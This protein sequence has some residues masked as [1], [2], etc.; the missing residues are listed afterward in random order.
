LN[1][2]MGKLKNDHYP[3]TF[4]IE[5]EKIS[6]LIHK[7]SV[8]FFKKKVFRGL[9]DN[10]LRPWYPFVEVGFDAGGAYQFG[11][12]RIDDDLT[13]KSNLAARTGLYLGTDLTFYIS[14]RIGYGFKYDYRSLLGG[15][16]YYQYLGPMATVRFLERKQDKH[17]FFSISCGAGWMVQKNAP[18]QLVQ[19]RPRIEMNA[20]SLSGD[21]TVGYSFKLAKYVS[22]RLKASCNIG[23]PSSVTIQDAYLIPKPD[24]VPFAIG[25]YCHN[26]NTINLTAGFSFHK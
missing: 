19:L 21:I 20:S 16:L 1:C 17:L 14:K 12:F 13:D 5:N 8:F 25:D 18:I 22:V 2:T 23:Y 3:I 7:D 11:K 4:V 9:Q 24:N 26:M 6:G 15:D 10:R